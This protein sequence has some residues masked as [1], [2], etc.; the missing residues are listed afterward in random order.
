MPTSRSP[1]HADLLDWV[2][3]VA[4]LLAPDGLPPIAG[5]ILGWLMICDPPQQPAGQIADA[6]GASRASLTVNMRVLTTMGFVTRQPRPGGRTAYYRIDD[7]AWQQVVRRQID[8]MASYLEITEDGMDLVGPATV[9]AARIR[10]AH[11][12]FTWMAKVFADAPPLP[13]RNRDRP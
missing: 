3:R 2:E 1:T 8:T 10:D 13:T 11:D 7:N 4:M 6:I 5:R 12:V 9:R